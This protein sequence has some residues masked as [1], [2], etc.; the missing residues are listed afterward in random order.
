MSEAMNPLHIKEAT[1]RHGLR[2]T[3]FL[4]ALEGNWR[5]QCIV[6]TCFIS[7][8]TWLFRLSQP[9]SILKINALS[10]FPSSQKAVA[11]WKR[12]RCNADQYL[13]LECL[14][15]NPET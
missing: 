14:L 13:I 9:F 11:I 7:N 8:T 12:K 10:E 2:V 3:H 1:D 5:L 6:L 15:E 4:S